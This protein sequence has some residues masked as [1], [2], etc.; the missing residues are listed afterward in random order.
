MGDHSVTTGKQL[1]SLDALNRAVRTWWAVVGAGLLVTIGDLGMHLV[2]SGNIFSVDGWAAVGRGVATAL[3]SAVFSY[4]AR[5]KAPPP[6]VPDTTTLPADAAIPTLDSAPVT[7]P[8]DV[9]TELPEPYNP[10]S[11]P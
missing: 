3:L 9:A 10:E 11:A 2:V 6:S 8:A 7:A 1:V 5:F 4:L